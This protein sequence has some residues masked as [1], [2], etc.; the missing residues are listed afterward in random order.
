YSC[1]TRFVSMK[2]VTITLP[3]NMVRQ[4]R[5]AAAVQGKSLS[6]FVSDLVSRELG[7]DAEE[8][9][10]RLERCFSGPGFPGA[11]KAW[12]GRE[13]L[14][15]ERE[16]ELLRRYDSHRLHGRS[17]RAGKAADRRELAE[18]DDQEPYAGPQP[19]KPE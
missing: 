10:K 12:P 3:E 5:I 2:N 9:L 19:A 15:A 6:K 14:Y 7:D 13:A 17:E 4:A 16:D 8:R 18:K 1:N 11:A